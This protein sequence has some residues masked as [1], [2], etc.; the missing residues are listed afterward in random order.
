MQY[1]VPQFIEIE[2]KIF[3]PL[4]LKQ[5]IY[6]AGA[7]GLCLLFFT[8]LP[9][10]VAV[11]FMIP[12]AALGLALAFYKVNDRP[13]IV[14]MEHALGYFFGTKLYLWKQREAKQAP[15]NP[16]TAG[17][18]LAKQGMTTLA[19]P[20]LS[21]SRLKDLSWSLNIKDR[22]ATGDVST[23]RAGFEI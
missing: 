3:G 23:E 1:Q 14:V 13:F 5:F 16:M 15:Q 12:A 18:A 8:I 10:Y 22:A 9:I 2:D 4:T 20:K 6:L 11:L 17:D 7:G 19:V 21:E